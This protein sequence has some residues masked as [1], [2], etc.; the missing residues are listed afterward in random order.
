[1]RGEDDLS[2]CYSYVERKMA[3]MKTFDEC[4]EKFEKGDIIEASIDDSED[5]KEEGDDSEDRKENSS[6]K[7]PLSSNSG[8]KTEGL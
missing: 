3:P 4:G 6:D 5:K 2:W 7:N 1:M 8:K